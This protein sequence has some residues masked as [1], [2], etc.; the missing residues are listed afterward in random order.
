MVEYSVPEFGG[1][2]LKQKGGTEKNY[3]RKLSV[4]VKHQTE[5]YCPNFNCHG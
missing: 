4:L 3:I 5:L 1:N 2:H